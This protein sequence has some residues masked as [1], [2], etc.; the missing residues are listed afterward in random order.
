[1]KE[2]SEPIIDTSKMSEAKRAAFLLDSLGDCGGLRWKLLDPA[3]LRLNAA[4]AGRRLLG[5]LA[6]RRGTLGL[7]GRF[8]LGRW[9]G[10]LADRSAICTA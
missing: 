2:P 1:M 7:G 6:P 8:A 4:T 5:C 3:V 9:H 10:W